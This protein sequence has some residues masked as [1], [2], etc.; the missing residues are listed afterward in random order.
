M[1][2][3]RSDEAAIERIRV[4]ALSGAGAAEFA[5]LPLPRRFR[6]AVTERGDVEGAMAIPAD[7]RRPSSFLRTRWVDLPPLAPD[8]VLVAVMASSINYNTVWSATFAPVPTFAFLD[9]LAAE[10]GWSARHGGDVHVLG[11]D[12]AGVVL[13][14]GELVHGWE[15]G[16]HVSVHGNWVHAEDPAMQRD[17]MT[18][19]SQRAWGF[20]TNFGGLAELAVVR[21]SQLLPKAPH[22]SWEEAA[23]TTLCN[24][25]SYRMLVSDNGARV[26]LGDRVLVWGATGGIGSFALQLCRAAGV[27]PV[28]V[29]G[30]AARARRLRRL[31]FEHVIDRS[32]EGYR[33]LTPD[34]RVDDAEVARFAERVAGLAGGGVDAVFEHPGRETLPASIACCRPGG[35]IV[36]CAATTGHRMPVGGPATQRSVR[37]VGSHFANYLENHRANE[38]VRRGVVHPTLTASVGLDEVGCAADDVRDGRH[39]GKVGVLCLAPPGEGIT[40]PA[41]RRRLGETTIRAFALAGDPGGP[42]DGTAADVRRPVADPGAAEASASVAP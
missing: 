5:G 1:T 30:N 33:F 9:R 4:A 35:A 28:A 16:D 42:T 10:G 8:E 11:S 13:R 6:A 25:T 32:E 36:T 21:A 14:T 29:V 15:P 41:S 34:D 18:A 17:G 39:D 2:T 12:A 26:R 27:E 3:H 19:A 31:G 7:R 37:I 40:D 22:L 23:S 20:E 24:A 38:L